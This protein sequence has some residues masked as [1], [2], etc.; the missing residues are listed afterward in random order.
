MTWGQLCLLMKFLGAAL[1]F[2]RFKI[3]VRHHPSDSILLLDKDKE[4]PGRVEYVVA[5]IDR[6]E[7]S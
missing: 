6:R 4:V 2:S 1:A 5:V 3:E 7:W